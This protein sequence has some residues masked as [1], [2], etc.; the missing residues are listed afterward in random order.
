M[1]VSNSYQGYDLFCKSN[2][3]IRAHLI[4]ELNTN[5]IIVDGSTQIDDGQWHFVVLTY[6][7]SSTAAGIKIYIELLER[8]L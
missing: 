8:I 3:V 5:E 4:N 6:N 1:N 7:G 2:G